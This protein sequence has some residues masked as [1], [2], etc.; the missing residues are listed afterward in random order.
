M[1][2]RVAVTAF[3][4]RIGDHNDRGRSGAVLL[5]GELGRRFGVDVT[6]IGTPAAALS[7]GW[8]EELTAA[9]PDLEVMARH[10][11]RMLDHRG[12][13]VSAIGRCATALA[14][15]PV[16]ARHRPDTVVVWLDG[17]ADLNTPSNT[18]TGYLG[19]LA[20]SGALGFWPSGLGG[21]LALVNT[22]LVGARD[23][24]PP[25]RH[26]IDSGVV[27]FIPVLPD[28]AER[29]RRAVSGRPVY[30]HLDCDVLEPGIVPTDYRVEGGFSLGEL[31][32]I[33][34]VL[35]ESEVVGLEIGEF[36]ADD[37]DARAELAAVALL[38]ALQP[39]LYGA[40][41]PR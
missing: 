24:D 11:E 16:L 13:P 26:L 20:L 30:V 22:I 4:G 31:N 33:A 36:E 35:A 2:P 37:S 14:T 32:E 18:E 3:I 6:P 12:V 8:Q 15:L 1:H 34:G 27:G 38:D 41:R 40:A 7:A 28:S 23:I 17:H 39:L 10:Y 5:A 21:D 29:I 19:G 25:E 9:R